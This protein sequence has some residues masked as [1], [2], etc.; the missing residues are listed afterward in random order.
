MTQNENSFTSYL[1]TT[2]TKDLMASVVVFL[3]ALP[4]C[5]G[6]AI[7]SGVP[8]AYGIIT[9]IIGG[10]VVGT[11]AGSP[12][13]VSGPAA[14]LTVLV[15]QFVQEH[16]VAMLGPAVAIAG[17]VQVVAGLLKFGQWFRAISPAVIQGMLAGIGVLIIGSQTHVLVDD[18]PKGSGLKNLL[19]IPSAIWKGLMPIEG[20]THHLA[21][22]IGM[23]TIIIMVAWKFAPKR[24]KI[25]PA[26][27]LAVIV[28]TGVA[29]F[30]KLPIYYVS[31]SANFLSDIA[32]P[33]FGAWAGGWNASILLGGVAIALIASAETLLCATAV[34]QMH[35]GPRTNY[36]RELFAQGVGNTLCGLLGSLPMTGVIVRSSANIEAGGRTRGSAIFHGIWL[37]AA[38]SLL[39]WLLNLIPTTSLAAILVFTGFKLVSPKAIR[40]LRQYGKSE[41][42]IYAA[43]VIAIVTADLLKGV[44]FGLALSLAKLIYTF[45]HLEVKL[46]ND[47]PVKGQMTMELRGAATFVRLPKLAQALESVP[48]TTHL[49]VVLVKLDYIDHACIDLLSNWEK[50]HEAGGGKII[51]E[52]DTLHRKYN[53]RTGSTGPVTESVSA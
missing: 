15:W 21:A 28:A 32:G 17:L 14:G 8:P 1:Q 9:G 44:L 23:L 19:S 27:L 34:D 37:L 18:G 47:Q 12:L 52:W 6:I 26:P 2:V 45:S 51:M 41:V 3:V 30:F 4:L 53:E 50:Q 31:V 43:T 13:Q 35:Q 38:V 10:I 16:G 20:N 39:P 11:L 7:A 42:A 36:D 33:S 46:I 49:H 40:L 22:Y 24:L 25:V 48:G 29:G 5:M